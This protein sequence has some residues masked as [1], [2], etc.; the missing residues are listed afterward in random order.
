MESLVRIESE[1]GDA[2]KSIFYQDL[3]IFNSENHSFI[4]LT[5]NLKLMKN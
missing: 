2:S 3:K 1:L 4:K 5:L